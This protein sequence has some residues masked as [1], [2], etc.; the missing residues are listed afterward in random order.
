MVDFKTKRTMADGYRV[1]MFE[2]VHYAWPLY[3]YLQRASEYVKE[4][5][6]LAVTELVIGDPFEVVRESLRVTAEQMI[7]WRAQAI[8]IQDFMVV[9]VPYENWTRCRNF[10]FGAPCDFLT[11]CWQDGG[12][13]NSL[14]YVKETPRA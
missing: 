14:E 4:P 2:D 11:A 8:K 9:D 10:G 12:T 5:V 7:H 6:R 13:Q 1:A 3:D